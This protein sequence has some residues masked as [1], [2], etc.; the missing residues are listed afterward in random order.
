M[1][2]RKFKLILRA[3]LVPLIVLVGMFIYIGLY[4][5]HL[6]Q[7]SVILALTLIFLGS[8]E[9]IKET[10]EDL[11]NKSFGLDYIA[12]LAVIVAIFTQEYLVGI[13]I[14]IMLSTGRTLEDYGA[15]S[16]KKSLKEL[17]SRVPHDV[18]KEFGN[19]SRMTPVS[20]IK[21]GDI[22][23]VRKGEVIPLDGVLLSNSGTLDESSLTGEAYPIDKNKGDVIRSGTVNLSTPLRIEVENDQ[24][25]SS[26]TKIVNLVAAAQKEKAPL[27]RLADKY[28]LW[29]TVIT[30]I[31]AGFAYYQFR[32]LESILAV[33]VVATPCPLIL[34]TPIALMGGMNKS[35]KNRVIIKNLSSIEVLARVN[36]LVFDKTGTLTLGKPEVS[37]LEILNDKFNEKEILS[38]AHAI[39][40]NSLHPLA[41]A[42]V[43]YCT[44]KKIKP[45]SAEKI[46]EV[47]GKGIEGRINNKQYS[48]SK[49][50]NLESENIEIGL[51]MG[52]ELLAIFTLEDQIKSDT[53]SVI[54]KLMQRGMGIIIFTGDKTSVTKKLIEKLGINID[55]KADLKPED[56]QKGIEDLKAQKKVVAMVGDGINDAPALALADVGMVFSNEEQT[57]SSEAADIIFLNGNFSSVLTSI[58]DANNTIKIAKQSILWGIGLSIICMIL[59]SFGLIPPIVGAVLQEGID[60]AVIL[61][62]LRASK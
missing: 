8:W 25:N 7:A 55:F 40:R 3:F 47:I 19:D 39:E 21:K 20:E 26:Y 4:L 42:I 27:V 28:S 62:A 36:T 60:V 48:L 13:V 58:Q 14:A 56:K 35:A 2:L 31:I 49:V 38:I 10:F 18:L 59:A 24:A 16:A 11:K 43:G 54:E 15:N 51:Y 50:T 6:N 5:S 12:I 34:A 61:N 17:A 52:K 32:T 30:L 53:K 9:L 44:S 1:N 22:I 46:H 57:A 29:F 23:V 33:L 37:K 45:L 41:K